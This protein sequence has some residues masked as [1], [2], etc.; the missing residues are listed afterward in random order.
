MA[1]NFGFRA[2][3][4]GVSFLYYFYDKFCDDSCIYII[5]KVAHRNKLDAVSLANNSKCKTWIVKIFESECFLK[6]LK[7]KLILTLLLRVSLQRID[8]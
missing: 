5:S 2:W 8:D 3:D 4:L 6:T 1:K 7:W